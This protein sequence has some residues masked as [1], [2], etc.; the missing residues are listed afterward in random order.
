MICLLSLWDKLEKGQVKS[1]EP[2]VVTPAE[3]WLGEV[4]EAIE[5]IPLL[6]ID[7]NNSLH[8]LWAQ[9]MDSD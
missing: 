8:N 4:P 5:E 2:T 7:E 6:N 9:G 1:E 3:Q